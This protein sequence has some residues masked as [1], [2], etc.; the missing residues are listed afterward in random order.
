MAKK[1]LTQFSSHANTI[2]DT[3]RAA[4]VTTKVGECTVEMTAP[5]ES[6]KG[7]LL[8][9]QHATLRTPEGRAIVVGTVHAGEKTA[10][11]RA[12]SL[13]ARVYDDRFQRQPPFNEKEYEAFLTKAAPILAAFALEQSVT[14]VL[15][16]PPKP[17]KVED[18]IP[19]PPMTAK[20][21]ATWVLFLLA[22]VAIVGGGLYWGRRW[23]NR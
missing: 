11:F 19:P 7:G 13:V 1:V 8:G 5:E 12:W 6:T 20:R 2:A 17:P 4:F 10:E 23:I 22:L 9:L 21:V 15:I 18:S 3:F 14:D 16:E